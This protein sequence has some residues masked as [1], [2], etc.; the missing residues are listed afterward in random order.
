MQNLKLKNLFWKYLRQN[1]NLR[2]A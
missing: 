2:H 1:W